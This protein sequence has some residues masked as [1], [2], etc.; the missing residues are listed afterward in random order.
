MAASAS[1]SAA[2]TLSVPVQRSNLDRLIRGPC[3]L[4]G[5]RIW[6]A[7]QTLFDFLPQG[8]QDRSIR[9]PPCTLQGIGALLNCITD[10]FTPQDSH[11]ALCRAS[12]RCTLQGIRALLNCITDS[13][14]FHASGFSGSQ[15]QR[16]LLHSAGHQGVVELHHRLFSVSRLRILTTNQARL[17]QIGSLHRDFAFMRLWVKLIWDTRS[18]WDQELRATWIK[19]PAERISLDHYRLRGSIGKKKFFFNWL[20]FTHF[21]SNF[22]EIFCAG[23]KR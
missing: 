11:T 17:Q 23:V 12:R 3:T 15:H 5:I 21:W 8:S 10:S 13:F 19:N 16:A 4:Q 1:A 14:L 7:S 18:C 6:I 9:G 20:A 2:P 22:D